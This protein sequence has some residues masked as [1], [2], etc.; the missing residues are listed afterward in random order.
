MTLY[1]SLE[2]K[3]YAGTTLVT[4]EYFAAV[5]RSASCLGK[6]AYLLVP[7]VNSIPPMKFLPGMGT[8]G[9]PRTSEYWV[10][11]RLFSIK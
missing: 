9:G 11:L 4:T 6:E 1:T 2:Q 10:L 5:R 8:A 3:R 7:Q